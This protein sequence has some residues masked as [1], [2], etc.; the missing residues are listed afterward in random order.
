MN[1]VAPNIL[2][3]FQQM[4]R[5]LMMSDSCTYFVY[6][7]RFYVFPNQYIKDISC[8]LFLGSP[9]KPPFIASWTVQSSCQI[10]KPNGVCIIIKPHNP[11]PTTSIALNCVSNAKASNIAFNLSHCLE[12]KIFQ[13]AYLFPS[14]RLQFHNPH[15]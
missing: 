6:L 15:Y 13:T 1:D 12:L 14:N 10:F 8:N 9:L 2:D 7:L 11:F 5:T 3:K 4:C